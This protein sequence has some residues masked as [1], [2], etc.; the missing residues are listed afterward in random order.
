MKKVTDEMKDTIVNYREA[1]R[2]YAFIASKLDISVGTVEYWC[3]EL[4]AE[5]PKSASSELPQTSRGPAQFTRGGHVVRR[6]SPKEDAK[7][8]EWREQNTSIA[9]CARRLGRRPH[10]VR[11]RLMAIARQEERRLNAC[12]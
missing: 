5:S 2:S 7:L 12:T 4:G 3:L 11:G 6:F 1:G 9:E 8:A 10:S